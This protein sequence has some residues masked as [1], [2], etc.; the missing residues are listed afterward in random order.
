M[1]IASN[2]ELDVKYTHLSYDDNG[3]LLGKLKSLMKLAK[4]DKAILVG[5]FSNEL[6]NKW[7]FDISHTN[8]LV[9]EEYDEEKILEFI[10]PL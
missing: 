5:D 4:V 6:L 2:V 10:S 7:G 3:I 8:L 1:K 9:L